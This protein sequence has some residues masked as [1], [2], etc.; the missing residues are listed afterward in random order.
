MVHVSFADFSS[1][2]PGKIFRKNS[3]P[4]FILKD[5]TYRHQMTIGYITYRDLSKDDLAV[6]SLLDKVHLRRLY[7]G[8]AIFAKDFSGLPAR[9]ISKKLR[10]HQCL[11]LPRFVL[12]TYVSTQQGVE[13]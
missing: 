2:K 5:S 3:A 1:R 4:F 12:V 9:K 10:D 11:R 13:T 6:M 8:V 7:K